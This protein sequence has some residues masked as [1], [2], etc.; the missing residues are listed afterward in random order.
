LIA[1]SRLK[2][3]VV[4]GAA[5]AADLLAVEGRSDVLGDYLVLKLYPALCEVLACRCDHTK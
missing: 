3:I 2:V 4:R 1:F 5:P